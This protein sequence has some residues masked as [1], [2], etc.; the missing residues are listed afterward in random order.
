MS[1]SKEKIG[2][3]IKRCIA[4][5]CDLAS[6]K[7]NEETERTIC[8]TYK[9]EMDFVY[10][11]CLNGLNSAL[12]SCSEVIG[13][14]KSNSNRYEAVPTRQSPYNYVNRC[15]ICNYILLKTDYDVLPTKQDMNNIRKIIQTSL[16]QQLLAGRLGVYPCYI[17]GSR[18]VPS[19]TIFD[20]RYNRPYYL[21]R[22]VYDR[23]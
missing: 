17:I 1:D 21:M 20:I 12:A 7:A 15:L 16:Y 22:I 19:L 2:N 11:M 23:L 8:S 3:I 4:S 18:R 14:K 5:L 9:Q 6:A 10:E 13:I